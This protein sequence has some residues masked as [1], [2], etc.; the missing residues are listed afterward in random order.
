VLDLVAL[1]REERLREMLAEH[2][3]QRGIGR[4]RGEASG[5]RIGSIGERD[6]S[7]P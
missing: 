6:T 3:S 7:Y 4:Q 1:E 5:S 2:L